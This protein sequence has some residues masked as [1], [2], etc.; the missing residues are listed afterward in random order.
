MRRHQV[1]I[2]S[3]QAIQTLRKQTQSRLIIN[4]QEQPGRLFEIVKL[5][6]KIDALL[7]VLPV[8]RLGSACLHF[9]LADRDV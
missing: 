6:K 7:V 8:L 4:D 9:L 2:N 1:L 5:S 3:H